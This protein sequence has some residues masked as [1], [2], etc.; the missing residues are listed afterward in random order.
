MLKSLKNKLRIN[1]TAIILVS[2]FFVAVFLLPNLVFA[3]ADLGMEYGAQI[4]L[5]DAD[6]RIMIARVIQ[7]ALGFLGIIAVGLIM[8]AGWMWMTS[9]GN[10]E[11]IEKAKNILKNAIIGL[12]IILS[13]FAIASF[14]LNKLTGATGGR[15]GENGG[16]GGNPG[17]GVGVLGSCTVESVYPEPDRKEVPRNTS[18]IVSFREEIDASTVMDDAGDILKDGRIMIYKSV[19]EE[20]R[21]DKFI[22]EIKVSTKDNKTF[23]FTPTVYLGSPSES[24]WY[25]I[26]LSN[27]ITKADGEKV[28]DTCG[29]GYLEWQFQVSNKID[30]EP[31]QI[32]ALDKGGVSPKPASTKPRNS[33]IQINFNEAINPITVSGSADEVKDYIKIVNAASS[34]VASGGTCTKDADCLSF[35]CN[36]GICEG[37]NDYLQGKFVVSNQYK[38]IEFVSDN[39]CGVN[40]CGEKIYCLPGGSQIRVELKAATLADCGADNCA[41]R[42][43]Y[44]VCNTHCQ[45]A[46]GENYPASDAA[47]LDGVM[48]VALNSLDGNR[49]NGAQGPATF[50]EEKESPNTAEGD[51]YKWSFSTS[52]V[53][54]LSPPKITNI[55]QEDA[56]N[57]EQPLNQG[58]AGIHLANPILVTFD[59]P[60]M[61]SSLSTGS[62]IVNN[63]KEGGDVVHKRINLISATLVTPD[64]TQ[65]EP[66]LPGYWITKN[67]IDSDSSGEADKTVAEINHSIFGDLIK[68]R[69]QVGSGVKDI[70]QNCFKPSIGPECTGNNANPSCCPSGENINPANVP[71]GE[72]C[73]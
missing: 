51:N 20:T 13:S 40:G 43:P 2:V 31:P 28:F 29:R 27:D 15:G 3:Q 46:D 21:A 70:N 18:I 32:W 49:V 73:P 35:K 24:I 17:G 10:E 47:L 56:S 39:Q 45:D 9:E 22:K 5:G 34:P 16:A 48:D 52:D 37:T 11:K 38:T 54:D 30:L 58:T 53:I 66:V 19:D 50:Y 63:G 8:Y 57:T 64:P 65:P 25:T 36:L 72:N 6:P 14:I 61:S 23:V 12:I 67:D 41:S 33:V 42:S 4:G 55:S 7:V 26:Y 71:S 69:A 62:I 44:N 60:M 68:Y 1:K 59:K